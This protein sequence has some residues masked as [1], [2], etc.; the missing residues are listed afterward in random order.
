MALTTHINACVKTACSV[1]TFR[2]TTG[3][4]NVLTNSSGYGG[5]NPDVG[6][7]N[8][9]LL[10]ITA[11]DGTQYNLDLKALSA[12]FPTTNTDY[13]YIIPSNQIGGRTV[14]E[15]GLWEFIYYINDGINTYTA[16]KQSIFTCNANCCVKSMLLNIDP[17]DSSIQNKVNYKKIQEYNKAF[18]F[19][20]SLKY[21]AFCGNLS[22]F[23]NIKLVIDKICAKSNCKTCN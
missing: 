14:I 6:D 3:E 9:A 2:D 1:L 20:E 13:E 23:N 15:D 4:Y 17:L 16:V 21:Y 19:L 8:I 7:F 22:K 18:A 11:P 5:I 12:G 10:S